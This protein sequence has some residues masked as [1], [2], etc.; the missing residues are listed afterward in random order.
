MA[1]HLRQLAEL[2]G[3][4]LVGDGELLIEGA[5]TLAD[6]Q[7]GDI[8]FVDSA[9]RIGALAASKAAAVVTPRGVVP[10]SRPQIAVDSVHR[11]FTRIVEYF[12]P[13]RRQRRIGISPRAIICASVVLGTDVD[14]HPGAI[15]GDDV[16]LGDGCTIHSGVHIMAGC[17]LG[18]QVT[19]YPNAVLYEDTVV[20]P[21]TTIH[22]GAVLGASGFGYTLVDGRHERAAQLGHVEIGADVE[23]GALS[24]IDRGA[25]GPTIVGEGTKIDNLV[26]IAHNCRIGRHNLLCSQVGIAGSTTTGDYVVMAGQVGVRDHV[27]IGSHAVLAAMAGISNDVP[28]RARMMGIPAT[29]EREQKLKLAALSKLPEMRRQLRALQNQVGAL[30]RGTGGA[31]SPPAAA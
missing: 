18:K 12:R 15:I 6:A 5:A 26:M 3:G 14:V 19:V 16:E 1:I 17:R 8:A 31:E 7:S 24:T 30:I 11:A 2:V 23:I 29:P 27:H 10:G 4:Q 9:E 13:P 22:A 20:G 25:Y 28:E 21:R